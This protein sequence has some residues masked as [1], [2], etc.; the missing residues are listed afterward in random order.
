M[1][2]DTT[3]TPRKAPQKRHKGHWA[4]GRRIRVPDGGGK[5]RG[6]R[7]VW[8][9]GPEDRCACHHSSPCPRNATRPT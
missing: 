1:T 2:P 5:V 6:A 7:K 8:H 4:Y 9:E 3:S